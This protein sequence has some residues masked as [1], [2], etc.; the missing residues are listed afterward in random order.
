MGCLGLHFALDA[1]AVHELKGIADETERRDYVREDLEVKY[2]GDYPEWLAQTDKAWD[3]IHRALT[4]GKLGWDNG[5]YPLNHVILGGELLYT[6]DD[7]IMTLKTPAQVREI[8]A[9]LRDLT[10]NDFRKNYHAIDADNHGFPVG[11]EDF[12]YTWCLFQ[13][14]R[15]FYDRAATAGRYVLFTAEQ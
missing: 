4:D 7:Y 11:A 13:P 9:A 15:E 12:D 3:A 2:F 14:L 8:S 10:E 1:E 5:D 6:A